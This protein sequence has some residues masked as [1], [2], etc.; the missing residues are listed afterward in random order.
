MLET[1]YTY[2]LYHKKIN[3]IITTNKSKL[4]LQKEM[5]FYSEKNE[6]EIKILNSNIYTKQYLNGSMSIS[7]MH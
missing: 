7:R 6:Y 3:K 1:Y 5:S 4:V 2:N